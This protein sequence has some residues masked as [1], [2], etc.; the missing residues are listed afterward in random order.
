MS[1]VKC[2][3]IKGMTKE[4]GDELAGFIKERQAKQVRA[5]RQAWHT[6][7]K[8]VIL[9]TPGASAASEAYVRLKRAY[10]DDILIETMIDTVP[11]ADLATAITR[12]NSDETVHGIIVQ[13]PLDMIS[14]V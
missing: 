4:R 11:Q 1:G 9:K 10:G 12:Y 8:L 2:G 7:P 13:L 5:L 3:M 14:S 6:F